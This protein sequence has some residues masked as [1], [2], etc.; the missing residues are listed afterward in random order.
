VAATKERKAGYELRD[1]ALSGAVM[2][3]LLV[4]VVYASGWA[5]LLVA[6]ILVG[7]GLWELCGVLRAGGFRPLTWGCIV[8]G[9]AFLASGFRST[10][11]AGLA[12]GRLGLALVL[13]VLVAATLAILIVPRFGHYSRL[14]LVLTL[15]GALYVGVLA[16]FAL[17]IRGLPRG[18]DW[19]LAVL[20]SVSGA[21]VGA[22]FIGSRFGKHKLAPRISPKKTW[23]GLGGG[24]ISCVL[25]FVLLG[26]QLG[27]CTWPWAVLLGLAGTTC[28]IL[29][30]LAASAIKRRA[31]V[32]N[33]GKLIPGHGGVLD[34][35][36]GILVA[37]PVAYAIIQ[38]I[39]AG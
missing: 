8:A 7:I 12:G 39:R 1:R 34:R 38:L 28:D 5:L 31:G 18:S 2:I 6:G 4:S 11:W 30:D 17:L 27:L 23:E 3:A 25:L 20:A 22:Y 15:V 37:L 9:L 19:L 36:D 26:T 33:Y 14:D 13:A 21:D 29:G 16:S 10:E 35:I 32:K 24:A